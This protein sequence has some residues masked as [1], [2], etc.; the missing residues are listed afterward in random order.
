MKLREWASELR[1][2]IADP[3]E[4]EAPARPERRAEPRHDVAG[5]K[6]IIRQRRTLGILHLR[7]LSENGVSGITDMPLAVGSIVFLELTRRHFYAAEVRW[8]RSVTIGMKLFRP[9]RHGMLDR[10][11]EAH[12]ARRQERDA[13]DAERA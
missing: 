1:A 10:L 7:D 13:Q 6:I 11:I 4:D 12:R 3:G 9:M 2:V 5:H 8:A